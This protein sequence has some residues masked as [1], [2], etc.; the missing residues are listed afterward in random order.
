[1]KNN[2]RTNYPEMILGKHIG[3][4]LKK[5]STKLKYSLYP[6]SSENCMDGHEHVF[7][8]WE[9]AQSRKKY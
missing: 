3:A 7:L 4:D 6:P 2:P 5:S 8:G 1:M 9:I